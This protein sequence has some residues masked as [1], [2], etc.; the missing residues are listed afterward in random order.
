M[1]A[2]KNHRSS[3]IFRWFSTT[4]FSAQAYPYTCLSISPTCQD[5]GPGPIL[6]TEIDHNTDSIYLDR[7]HVLGCAQEGRSACSDTVDSL[8]T[9]SPPHR[10]SETSVNT[11]ILTRRCAPFHSIMTC[12]VFCPVKQ[13]PIRTGHTLDD[14][15]LCDTPLDI[16][17]SDAYFRRDG[18]ASI[19]KL[20]PHI[21]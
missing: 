15:I 11:Y 8:G 20:R 7:R 2:Y 10:L 3:C 18:R 21:K 4:V 19:V 9:A 14:V 17:C 16:A 6:G 13:T 12:C 5:R 1:S